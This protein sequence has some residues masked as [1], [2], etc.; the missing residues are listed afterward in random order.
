MTRNH[1]S[2]F[3]CYQTYFTWQALVTECL[4][5]FGDTDLCVCVWKIYCQTPAGPTG[6]W[7]CPSSKSHLHLSCERFSPC[8]NYT[9]H[10]ITS[11]SVV[12]GPSLMDLCLLLRSN[13]T[14]WR[15]LYLS[16][17]DGGF[18][19]RLSGKVTARIEVLT[20][21]ISDNQMRK[22]CI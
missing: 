17:K 15:L 9:T 3:A 6:T 1:S 10:L 14:C 11:H 22:Y 20:I 7:H 21:P 2:P 4:L 16:W 18:L 13:L 19:S 8:Y 12:L 5:W